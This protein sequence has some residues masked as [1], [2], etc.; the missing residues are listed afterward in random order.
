MQLNIAQLAKKAVSSALKQDWS[1][2]IKLN[3]EIIE[4]DPKNVDAKLR[5]GRAFLYTKD[6]TKAKKMFKE[7][8]TQ[9]PIN[10][11]AIKNLD[12]IN[13][14]K[15]SLVKDSKIDA[16]AL[17]KEPGTT[18]EVELEL[19][20]KGLKS[21]IFIPGEQF[22]PKIKKK[23]VELYKTGSKKEL[24]IGEIINQEAVLKLNQLNLEKG[25][26]QVSFVKGE[27]KHITVLLKASKTIFR[28]D[29]Q[30]VRPY[31]KKG[32]LDE[33]EIEEEEVDTSEA[34]M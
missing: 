9:D 15:V 30:D 19:T 2:A 23:S 22:T 25:T 1:E 31:I 4:I 11:V 14:N 7:V 16:K 24:L 26:C 13:T 32:S 12:M 17:I 8:L 20:A 10:Q 28:S 27:S 34:L 5:L 18:M 29:K 21:D 33:P 3:T 6:L